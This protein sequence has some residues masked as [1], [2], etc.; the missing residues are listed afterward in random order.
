MCPTDFP[1][2]GQITETMDGLIDPSLPRTEAWIRFLTRDFL[3]ELKLLCPR[4]ACSI[5]LS[6]VDLARTSPELTSSSGAAG[7]ASL[8]TSP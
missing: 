2:K 8:S 4:L 3:R 5:S 6:W 1:V 7:P